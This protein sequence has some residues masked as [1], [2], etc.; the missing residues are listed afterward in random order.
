MRNLSVV[1][2]LLPQFFVFLL[3]SRGA[4]HFL[5]GS[6]LGCKGYEQLLNC[7]NLPIFGLLQS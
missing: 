6:S 2:Q 5:I 4:F 1:I 7:C 3:F